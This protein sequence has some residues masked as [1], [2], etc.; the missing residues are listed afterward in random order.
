MR[1]SIAFLAALAITAGAAAVPALA[2]D[3][4]IQHPQNRVPTTTRPQQ[5]GQQ[6]AGA[7]QG[8]AQNGMRGVGCQRDSFGALICDNGAAMPAG[9]FGTRPV[10]APQPG[11]AGAG[12]AAAA[13]PP[14][15]QAGMPNPAAM[16]QPNVAEDGN[17]YGDP[18]QRSDTDGYG[19]RT[20]ATGNV[21]CN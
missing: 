3:L 13:R 18:T 2:Q 4:T 14:A 15:A 1:Q 7:G 11:M 8:G 20:D 19:C 5:P 6:R 17:L 12:A 10:R 16:I 9:A 21:T